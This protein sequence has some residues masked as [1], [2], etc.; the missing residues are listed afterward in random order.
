[1][2]ED[3]VEEGNAA[4]GSFPAAYRQ[5]SRVL[6]EPMANAERIA[7]AVRIDPALTARLLSFVNAGH[8]QGG[9]KVESVAHAAMLLGRRQLQ[10]I[11]T[12]SSV[13]YM[14]R[15]IPEHLIDMD[16]FWRHSL[17]VGL[18]A[19]RLGQVSGSRLDPFVP[20]LLHDVGA[21]ILFL[22]RPEQARAILIET[23][24]RGGQTRLVEREHLGVD[25]TEI[26]SR[27]QEHW[28]LLET[29]IA[30]ARYHHSPS[31]APEKVRPIVDLV[32]LADVATS[33]L[34]IGNAGERSAHPLDELAWIRAGL[35]PEQA[36]Q[37]LSD[38]AEE[39][40]EIHQTLAL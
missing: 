20:G 18:G 4:L 23:E 34:Q 5:L 16:A 9:R 10:E 24:N 8:R 22:V 15:G 36:Y 37:A 21:L 2:V 31:E 17:A 13:V 1:M 14:F 30:V 26:G 25:H 3:L 38:L 19:T 11:A 39:V 27:L 12:A 35:T 28:G 29:S 6:D 7:C 32:H 33:A 40:D